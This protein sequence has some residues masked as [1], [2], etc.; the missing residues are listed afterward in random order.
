MDKNN[1]DLGPLFKDTGDDAPHQ[2][3]EI[4]ERDAVNA[5][6]RN[7]ETGKY[8]LMKWKDV[9]WTAFVTGGI[10]NGQTAE[11]AARTEVTQETG[12]LNLRLICK[13]PRYQALFWHGV[14]KVNRLARFQN[15]LFE[16]ENEAKAD[17]SDKENQKHEPIWLTLD[18]LKNTNL[19]EGPRFLLDHVVH[20]EL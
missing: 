1:I 6:V 5:V 4:I 19:Q 7:P 8:L 18:E 17:V 3:E 12:Y 14:K 2:N 9:N 13:L 16:L 20:Q 10:E 11:E 15:F